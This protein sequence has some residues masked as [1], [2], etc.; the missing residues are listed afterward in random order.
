MERKIAEIF[1]IFDH[2]NNKTVDAREIGTI[3]RALECVPT[4]AELQEMLVKMEDPENPGTIHLV[5]FIPILTQAITEHK[6]VPASPDKLLEAFH[7]LDEKGVGYLTKQQ[8]TN[9]MT[10]EGEPFSQD[11]LDEMLE[12][13]IDPQTQTVPYEYYI[14]QLMVRITFELCT[15]ILIIFVFKKHELK[16]NN[17]YEMADVIAAEKV[18]VEKKKMSKLF[19]SFSRILEM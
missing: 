4:E 19:R 13:A 9:I 10:Q 18:P 16:D 17:V 2:A 5:M 7:I 12:I 14:N 1:D 3:I 15:F 8:I 11:E 6:F